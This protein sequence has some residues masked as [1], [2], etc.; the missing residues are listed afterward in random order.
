MLDLNPTSLRAQTANRYAL[1]LV[2]KNGSE[3]CAP[4]PTDVEK[5]MQ[6]TFHSRARNCARS[7]TI[8]PS[9]VCGSVKVLSTME[10]C[11]C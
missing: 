2:G 3:K 6:S 9:R 10:K 7:S 5:D 11:R 8:T 4:P 1:L